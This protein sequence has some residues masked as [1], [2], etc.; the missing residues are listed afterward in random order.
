MIKYK[1]DLREICDILNEADC[2]FKENQKEEIKE[3]M[4]RQLALNEL[5]YKEKR[6]YELF[7]ESD[8]ELKERWNKSFCMKCDYGGPCTCYLAGRILKKRG[9][10]VTD[11]HGNELEAIEKP[12]LDLDKEIDVTFD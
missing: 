10:N 5:S 12:K 4:Q 6:I 9:Y 1:S 3:E 11:N 7:E 8:E 2:S